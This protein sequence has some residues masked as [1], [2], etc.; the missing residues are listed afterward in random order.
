MKSAPSTASGSGQQREKRTVTDAEPGMQ[1][2]DPWDMGIGESTTLPRAPSAN[3]RRTKFV[4]LEPV[5]FTTQDAVDGYREK[6][7][8]IASVGQVEL[9]N[10]MELS[11][12]GHVLKWARRSNLSGGLSLRKVNRWNLKNHSNLT[13]ARHLREK[14]HTRMLLVTVREG[15]E[16]EI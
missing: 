15:E 13:V 10:I 14:I 8:G 2:G 6:A 16:R 4:K 11:I 1:T 12:T 9:G 5:A 3:T 7:M